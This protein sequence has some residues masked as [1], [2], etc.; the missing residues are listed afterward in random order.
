M[1]SVLVYSVS[2]ISMS[3]GYNSYIVY[4]YVQEPGIT[5]VPGQGGSKIWA[6]F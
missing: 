3:L 1:Y 6:R 2:R 4:V 5:G